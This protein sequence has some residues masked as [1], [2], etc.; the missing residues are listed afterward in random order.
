MRGGLLS[1]KEKL[2]KTVKENGVIH[3]ALLSYSRNCK[4]TVRENR[5]IHE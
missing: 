2:K 5:V 4:K 1:H 3:E